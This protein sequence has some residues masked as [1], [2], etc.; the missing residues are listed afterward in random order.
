MRIKYL[1]SI[2]IAC[3]SLAACRKERISLARLTLVQTPVA[4]DLGGIWFSDA[5]NGIA[6]GGSAW[7]SGC[8]LSTTDGGRHWQ[9]D[10]ILPRRMEAVSMST[11]GRAFACGQDD[12]WFREPGELSWKI[13]RRDYIWARDCFFPDDGRGVSVHGESYRRGQ[14]FTF[15]PD[16]WW[17]TD[18]VQEF[19][20]ELSALCFSGSQTVHAVGFGW[21]LYSGDG[22]QH[23]TRQ[24][25]TGDFFTDVHFP[26]AKTGYLC[27][28]SGSIWKSTDGG[29]N[30]HE[31]RRGGSSGRRRQ[32]F[33]ALYFTDAR[34]GWI[35]GDGGLLWRTDDGGEH[36]EAVNDIPEHINLADVF[37]IGNRGWA[38][39]SGGQILDFEE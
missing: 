11:S 6:C 12:I 26:D 10:T 29:L 2:V 15:G 16:V 18:T 3:L 1:L 20:N 36:W 24:E 8:I 25:V 28:L 19:P 17:R 31:I 32:A 4:V 34:H 9:V 13:F 7:A 37:A 21:V 22:G 39:A 35:A 33:R 27:G 30:W 14:I 38:A 5:Q 23:W